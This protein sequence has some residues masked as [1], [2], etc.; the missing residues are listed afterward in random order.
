MATS[1]VIFNDLSAP[2]VTV[3][4]PTTTTVTQEPVTVHAETE[5]HTIWAYKPTSTEVSTWD[6]T[7]V[8]LTLAMKNNFHAF[9]YDDAVG[10]TNTF[11]YTHT[12]GTAYTLC[13]F[14]QNTLQW[15][16]RS[17]AL[18]DVAVRIRVPIEID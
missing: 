10:P 18:W 7:L 8:D 14:L 13:R 15:S 16:R 9:F 6:F 5:D 11:T 1:T 17:S 12:D 4:G 3:N 2:A